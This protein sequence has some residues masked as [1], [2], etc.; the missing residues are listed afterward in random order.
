MA[1]AIRESPANPGHVADC[2]ASPAFRAGA[3]VCARP[4]LHRPQIGLVERPAQPAT[5]ARVLAHAL[6]NAGGRCLQGASKR[7]R[8]LGRRSRAGDAAHLGLTLPSFARKQVRLQRGLVNR[9]ADEAGH[10]IGEGEVSRLRRR[11]ALPSCR[12]A[13]SSASASAGGTSGVSEDATPMLLARSSHEIDQRAGYCSP[14][15]SSSR[16]LLLATSR[17]ATTRGS[18]PA[19]VLAGASG[20]RSRGWLCPRAAAPGPAST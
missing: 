7:Q 1:P 20:P 13:Y 6:Q 4:G 15:E 10:E 8:Q 17:C 11:S 18:C 9:R 2:R 12:R 3:L 16:A 5:R 14:S 19:F